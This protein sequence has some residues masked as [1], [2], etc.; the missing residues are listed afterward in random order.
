MPK[1]IP[2]TLSGS[3]EVPYLYDIL[4]AGFCALTRLNADTCWSAATGVALHRDSA[5]ARSKRNLPLGR[6]ANATLRE[7]KSKL[8]DTLEPLVDGKVRRDGVNAFEARAT[9]VRW[10]A[11]ELGFDPVPVGIHA[12]APEQCK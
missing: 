11:T 9:A 1:Q 3:T 4:I 12:F 8:H 2:T 6:L 7:G 10:V 5:I